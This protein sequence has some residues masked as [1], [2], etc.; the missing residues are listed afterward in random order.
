M[1]YCEFAAVGEG[2]AV[3]LE[4]WLF[5]RYSCDFRERRR[6]VALIQETVVAIPQKE[7]LSISIDIFSKLLYTLPSRMLTNIR[8]RL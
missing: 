5:P 8:L 6:R 2:S 4:A 3:S 7:A 1:F